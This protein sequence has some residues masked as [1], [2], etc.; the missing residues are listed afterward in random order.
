MISI[1]I[2]FSLYCP[3]CHTKYFQLLF[4]QL[5][6]GKYVIPQCQQESEV[7]RGQLSH[8]HETELV[9][10]NP[11]LILW[12]I[13]KKNKCIT[14]LHIL[15]FDSLFNRPHLRGVSDSPLPVAGTQWITQGHQTLRMN[16]DLQPILLQVLKV[17]LLPMNSRN[18]P[19]SPVST[20]PL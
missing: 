9:L 16:W 13:L 6:D 20:Y 12:C 3:K 11:I 10:R 17:K 5:L 19:C 15:Y 2:N 4:T 18:S 1:T 8:S 7:Q 14:Y